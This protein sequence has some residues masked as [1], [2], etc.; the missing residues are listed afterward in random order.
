VNASSALDA[1]YASVDPNEENADEEIEREA[2][3]E[4]LIVRRLRPLR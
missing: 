3:E 2:E 4:Y 1:M